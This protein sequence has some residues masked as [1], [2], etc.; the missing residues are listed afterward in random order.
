MNIR[1]L[2]DSL[3]T[4]KTFRFAKKPELEGISF[5]YK[6]VQFHIIDDTF[7]EI[8]GRTEYFGD[9]KI[10]SERFSLP[11]F[12]IKNEDLDGQEYQFEIIVSIDS[13]TDNETYI[14]QLEKVFEKIEQKHGVQVYGEPFDPSGDTAGAVDKETGVDSEYYNIHR[15]IFYTKEDDVFPKE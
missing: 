14:T 13:E 7:E 2:F 5:K 1:R 10:Y 8:E 11:G 12:G 3:K 9:V 15:I 4:A 6:T